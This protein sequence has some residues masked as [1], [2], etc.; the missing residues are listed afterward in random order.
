MRI[1]YWLSCSLFRGFFCLLYR[2]KVY[3]LENLPQGGAII[4]PNHAS[5]YD[6]P[7]IGGSCPGEA[8]FF[9]RDTLFQKPLLRILIRNLNAHPISGTSQDIRS[10]KL[11]L[12]LLSEGKKVVIFPEGIRSADESLGT[13]KPGIGMLALRCECP[14]IPVYIHGTFSIWPRSERFP[15]LWGKTACVF[16]TPVFP[17]TFK[18]LQRK[19][20]QEALA[21]N[22][23]ESI[24]A[25][26]TWYLQGAE[27]SPP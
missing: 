23:Y 11:A 24:L 9:A 7:I 1:F 4:A 25:L 27:G 18:S 26:K 3:G 2:H 10:I 6:P 20:A 8:H 19:E 12:Q 13:I 15:K 5:Y 14:I 21:Q 22:V 17:K 16:G